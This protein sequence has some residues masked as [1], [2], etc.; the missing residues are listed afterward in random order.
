MSDS[1]SFKLQ[2]ID[3]VSFKEHSCL[4]LEDLCFF[5]GDYAGGQGFSHSEMNNLIHNFKKPREKQKNPQ[6]WR[7]KET[8]IKDIANLLLLTPDWKKLKNCVWIPMPS[9]KLKTDSDYDDRLMQVLLKIKEQET[10]LD[11]RELLTIKVGYKAAHE[12]GSKRLS[13]P[14]HEKNFIFDS[15]K[16]EPTPRCIVIFDDVITTGASFKAAQNY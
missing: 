10:T 2:K 14:E 9:S 7:H 3:G 15:S 11:V 4:T 5:F 6:E 8:A 1:Q 12:P 13:I 16:K